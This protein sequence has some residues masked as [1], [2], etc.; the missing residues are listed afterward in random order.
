M[1]VFP[2]SLEVILHHE[3]G[4]S[5]HPQDPGK[6]TNLGVTRKV[7]E[8]W[9]GYS[10]SE[11]D[12]RS[13]TPERVAPLYRAQYW[14]ALKCD[15][16]PP[17]VALCVFDFGVNAGVSRAARLLQQCVGSPMDGQIGKQTIAK[18]DAFIAER[19]VPELV[20]VYQN[21]RRGYYKKLH[22]FDTFGR[23]WLRRVDD[24]ETQALRMIK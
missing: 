19:G 4:W 22:H 16:L 5:N 1:D 24:V 3:G 9:Q 14:N 23:G 21:A 11:S 15:D 18:V 20:R 12:M 10:V 7:W 13:L 2:N 6:M 8:R 17:P